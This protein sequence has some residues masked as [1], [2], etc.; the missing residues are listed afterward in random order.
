[1]A[2]APIFCPACGAENKP[3]SRFCLKDGT[4][5]PALDPAR[6]DTKFDRAS[7]TY[8]ADEIGQATRFASMSVVRILARVTAE[9]KYPV[10]E[11]RGS[12]ARRE[13][14]FPY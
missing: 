10:V 2:G 8:S 12:P 11:L 5:L 14:T 7:E 13:A 4:P 9:L 3:G 6:I 1:M